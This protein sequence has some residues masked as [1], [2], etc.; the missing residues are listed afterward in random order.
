M[1]ARKELTE[2]ELNAFTARNDEHHAAIGAMVVDDA[3]NGHET[4]PGGIARYIAT[5]EPDRAAELAVT[6][7]DDR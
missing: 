5:E 1:A 7:V 6:V 4:V 3:A 2:S